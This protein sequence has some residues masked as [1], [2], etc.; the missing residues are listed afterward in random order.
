MLASLPTPAPTLCILEHSFV[1]PIEQQLWTSACP[2]PIWS[3]GHRTGCSCPSLD[4][5]SSH[6]LPLALLFLTTPLR[7]MDESSWQLS[8]G[9][10]QCYRQRKKKREEKEKKKEEKKKK[11][12][13]FFSSGKAIGDTPGAGLLWLPHSSLPVLGTPKPLHLS[14]KT[15]WGHDRAEQPFTAGWLQ[16]RPLSQR[17]PFSA[18]LSFIRF[19]NFP[20]SPLSFFDESF[21][22]SRG[23]GLPQLP[24]HSRV[25]EQ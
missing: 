11:K 1:H 10:A 14:P 4:C 8:P 12:S 5:S 15:L 23:A 3:L 19:S 18:V 13:T 25:G 22:V 2:S 9:L 20:R 24:A 6:L 21:P 16:V 17:M 7:P